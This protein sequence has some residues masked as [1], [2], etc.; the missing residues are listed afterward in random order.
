LRKRGPLWRQ[1]VL[2]RSF[3]KEVV[4]DGV[5]AIGGL[6]ST[7]MLPG[8]SG[9][10]GSSSMMMLEE[11]MMM[12]MMMMMEMSQQNGSGMMGGMGGGM[13]GG[14]GGGMPG[15]LLG[16]MPSSATNGMPDNN[17]FNNNPLL[18]NGGM[19]LNGS[20]TINF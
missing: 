18:D 17:P 14:F 10:S 7:S 11:L 20:I 13:P 2:D 16:A 15:S 9:M 8:M 5:S 6:G 4:M 1:N 12:L 19:P 3:S